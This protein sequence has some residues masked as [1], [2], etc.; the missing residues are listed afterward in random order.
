ACAATGAK[1]IKAAGTC[2]RHATLGAHGYPS[3]PDRRCLHGACRLQLVVAG[4]L[5][6]AAGRPIGE[7]P[8]G[9]PR[10]LGAAGSADAADSEPAGTLTASAAN[11]AATAASPSCR[12]R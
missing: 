8:A 11:R 3:F 9:A 1:G 10:C 6:A 7:R 2:A 12:C 5:G 4:T